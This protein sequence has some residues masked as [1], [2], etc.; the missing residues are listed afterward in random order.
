V[1]IAATVLALASWVYAGS[2]ASASEVHAGDLV[3]QV[4]VAKAQ[5]VG[6]RDAVT[7]A[8]EDVDKLIPK[9][10]ALE[11]AIK[12]AQ[13]AFDQHWRA[14]TK[15]VPALKGAAPAT[16]PAAANKKRTKP[17]PVE[18]FATG[19]T[20]YAAAATEGR[21]VL[22]KR[23]ELVKFW[24]ELQRLTAASADAAA[25]A[26]S[27]DKDAQTAAKALGAAAV[28]AKSAAPK[29]PADPAA[30]AAAEL[31]AQAEQAKKAALEA[32]TAAAAAATDVTKIRTLSGFGSA[33]ALTAKKATAAKADTALRE[34]LSSGK[35]TS[36]NVD[37]TLALWS[38]KIRD[39]DLRK[40]DWKNM[41]YPWIPYGT[42]SK[43]LKLTNGAYVCDEPKQEN[44]PGKPP[45]V[46]EPLYGDLSGDGAPAAVVEVFVG[47]G[48][49]PVYDVLV[50]GKDSECRLR[51][52]GE[53]PSQTNT[54]TITGNAYTADLPYAKKKGENVG[55]GTATGVEHQEW[56]IVK[57]ALKRLVDVKK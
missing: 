46:K 48:D 38:P 42:S 55:A 40:V 37:N 24:E 17:P 43:P 19:R 27:A 20:E 1:K 30:K 32:H 51:L 53:M 11:A 12:D 28:K 10:T 33:A 31:S 44:C 29:D 39:C 22:E 36:M 54:G 14:A 18:A 34:K 57:G 21:T 26:K 56:R 6:S 52:V 16:A 47:S 15:A 23:A 13:K 5:A 41:T 45:S 8:H 3:K 50:F 4:D 35:A 25:K 7:K 49:A 9:R 2:P